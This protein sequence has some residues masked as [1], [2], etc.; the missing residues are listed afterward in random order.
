MAVFS[1]FCPSYGK[2]T[3]GRSSQLSLDEIVECAVC[4]EQNGFN[5][6]LTP[7]DSNCYDPWMLSGAIIYRT[8]K[9]KPIIAIRTG[10]IEPVYAARMVSTL[11]QISKGRVEINIV[12]GGSIQELSKEGQ[13]LNHDDRYKRTEE[14][15]QVFRTLLKTNGP[16]SFSGQYYCVDQ[17]TLF[18]VCYSGNSPKIFVAGS[19]NSAK[20]VAIKYGDVYLLWAEPVHGIRQHIEELLQIAGGRIP[21]IGLR[22]N[23]MLSKG[24]QHAINKLNQF[25]ED[26]NPNKIP[27]KRLFELIYKSSD[28]IGQRR[29]MSLA[30]QGDLYDGNLWTGTL[31][32]R[33]GIVPTLVGT[34]VEICDGIK[35]YMELG[36]THFIVNSIGSNEE[37]K[38]IGEQVVGNLS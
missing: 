24:K 15:M 6:I 34:D 3:N 37:I 5:S 33:T 16:L 18:P 1:W 7:A 19:S 20:K 10:Y 29:M 32:G 30:Q 2:G 4:A 13:V 17:A 28:S 23:I 35:R 8:S 11:D 14:Y 27:K 38:L 21:D 36:I 26:N 22:V 25:Y 9:I 31:A 12:T